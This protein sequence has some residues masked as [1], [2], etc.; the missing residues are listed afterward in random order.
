MS[1]LLALFLLACLLLAGCQSKP[2]Q[3]SG[4]L[5]D[6]N[7]VQGWSPQGPARTYDTK[8]L[9]DLVDGQS[10]AFFA[11]NFEQV[12]VRRYQN[13]AGVQ[14]FAEIWQVQQPADAFGLFSSNRSGSDIGIG[15]EGD[16]DP[17]RR[18]AFW[19]NRYFVQVYASKTIPDADLEHFAMWIA[20]KLPQNGERP[21]LVGRAPSEGLVQGKLMYFHQEISVQ[22][23]LW[24]G[25]QNLLGLGADTEGILARYALSSGEAR[26]LL[27]Q[28]PDVQRA[29]AGLAGLQSA[30]VENL[31]ASRA[32]G[33]LLGAVIGK[34]S[35]PEAEALLAQA[36]K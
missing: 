24:L 3:L 12:A 26:L 27:V 8:N 17:G 29:S 31:A 9:Y 4:N 15:Y 1:K 22:N 2:A 36:L 28:Y 16:S 32:A 18:I 6:T 13:S 35:I 10:E 20:S 23:E 30:G 34:A 21:A 33:K 25:G 14:I 5:P 11:Y 7:T 19:Q